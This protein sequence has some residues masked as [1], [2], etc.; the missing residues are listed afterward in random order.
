MA[1]VFQDHLWDKINHGKIKN[2]PRP[3]LAEFKTVNGDVKLRLPTSSVYYNVK[4]G[5]PIRAKDA[6]LTGENSNAVVK[7]SDSTYL[8]VQPQTLIIVNDK[9]IKSSDL[10]YTVL[11]GEVS[12]SE[13]ISEAPPAPE[14][15]PQP[16]HKAT[17]DLQQQNFLSAIQNQKKYFF[18][19]YTELLKRDPQA[20]GQIN[21]SIQIEASGQVTMTRVLG[22]TIADSEM[23]K[24]AAQVMAR[25]K[26]KSFKGDPQ[27][28][29][30][31]LIFE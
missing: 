19:C 9:P 2:D 22:S 24:C 21:I 13:K 25:I 20:A 8:K 18:K 11:K 4:E 31:P 10:P 5:L 26:F 30:Y 27:I 28:V 29:N 17:P 1:T 3:A 7:F 14:S 12:P 23:Q 6:I 15:A 16:N